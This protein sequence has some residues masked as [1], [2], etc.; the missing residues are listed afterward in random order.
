MADRDQHRV[1]DRRDMAELDHSVTNETDQN[2]ENKQGLYEN[3]MP[4]DKLEQQLM[5]KEG[6]LG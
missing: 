4:V 6:D 2:V 3:D 1:S 5:S